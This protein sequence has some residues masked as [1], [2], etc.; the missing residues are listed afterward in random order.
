MPGTTAILGYGRFGRALAELV[1]D[2][3]LE[4]RAWDPTAEV[5]AELRASSRAELVRNAS[6]VVLAV[7]VHAIREA[8]LAVRP[9]L[10]AD[11]LTLDVSSVKRGP[12]RDLVEVLGSRFGWVA[13][14]PLFGSTS[15]VLG[16]RPLTAVV[17]P[18]PLHPGAA[19]TATRFY[20]RIG[21][22]VVEQ[23]PDEHDRGMAL[24]HAL[25]FFVAKGMIDIGV[26]ES[27]PFA[28]PSFQAMARTIESVRAD[29]SH[30]FRSIQTDNPFAAEARERLLGAL[31]GIHRQLS[32]DASTG[33]APGQSPD[34]PDLGDRAPDLREIRDLIDDT[35][36]ELVR[37]FARRDQLA[38]RA[39][40]V[41]A[42]EMRPIRD[43]QRERDMLV[44]R[45]RWAEQEGM[46]PRTVEELFRRILRVS[47][48]V[49][50][51]DPQGPR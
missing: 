4:V 20:E 14:H 34:I 26:L 31:G 8:A 40:R 11:S 36:R 21:C 51:E 5:P 44:E 1:L 7:P 48:S 17:C 3:G 18:N 25:A 33:P 50:K 35:D 37:L 16:E 41:K 32:T 28:P 42:R 6:Q 24:T 49:Q 27:V 30:L 13:T 47:R 46:D 10:P 39:G 23:D 19:A 9:Y 45:R 2:A 22:R 43:P 29:A 12:V 38:F 15:I